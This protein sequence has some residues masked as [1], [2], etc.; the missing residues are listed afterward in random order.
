[1]LLG[2]NILEAVTVDVLA[3]GVAHGLVAVAG[4]VLICTIPMRHRA[5]TIDAGRYRDLHLPLTRGWVIAYTAWNWAF[6]S[7]NYPAY[8]GHHAAVLLAALVVG[9]IAPRLWTQTRSSTLGLNLLTMATFNPEMVSWLD[10]SAWSGATASA[11]VAVA[12]LVVTVVSL[13]RPW[14]LSRLRPTPVREVAVTA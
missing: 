12:A 2:V 13:A 7:L 8:A 1:M 11:G 3:G 14:G 4:L 10:A 6:V 9:L 5:T